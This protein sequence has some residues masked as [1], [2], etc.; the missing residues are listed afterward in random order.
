M[1]SE[2]KISDEDHDKVKAARRAFTDAQYAAAES[3]LKAQEA[4]RK[5]NLL[6]DTLAQDY[7]VAPDEQINPH[8]G[9]ITKKPAAA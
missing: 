5:C 8:D 4:Q 3:Q 6:Y 2:R 9:S 1:T 7:S